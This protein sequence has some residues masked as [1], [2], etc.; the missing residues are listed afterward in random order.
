M[1]MQRNKRYVLLTHIAMR[2]RPDD[3]R[4]SGKS[5]CHCL[6]NCSKRHTIGHE[7]RF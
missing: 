4:M 1:Y 2:Y 5:M 7:A 6:L 3:V